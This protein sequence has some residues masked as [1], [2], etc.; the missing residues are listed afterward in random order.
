MSLHSPGI[1]FHFKLPM[2]ES[3]LLGK[4]AKVDAL[5]T[6]GLCLVSSPVTY[7]KIFLSVVFTKPA[8]FQGQF[9]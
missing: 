1:P 3:A 6:A 7:Y 9:P 8:G 2:S 5:K 4:I